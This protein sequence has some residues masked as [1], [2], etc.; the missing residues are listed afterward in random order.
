MKNYLKRP[1]ASLALGVVGFMSSVSL[2]ECETLNALT[3]ENQILVFDSATPERVDRVISIEGIGDET[4]SGIDYRPATRG[5]YAVTAEQRVYLVDPGNG[6]VTRVADETFASDEAQM[7]YGWD[8]NP[9]VDRL[10]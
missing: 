9:A 7:A 1:K 10:R 8:F 3:T 5:L 4:V 2:A 6:A